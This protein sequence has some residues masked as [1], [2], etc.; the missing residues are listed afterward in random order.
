MKALALV[1]AAA[2]LAGCTSNPLG[3][4]PLTAKEAQGRAD[5]AARQWQP[6]AV[7]IGLAAPE[8]G[9]GSDFLGNGNRSGNGGWPVAAEP[10][11]S[12]GDGRLPQ[13]FLN[14]RSA[15]T[16]R[17]LAVL[18][19]QN[20]TVRTEPDAGNGEDGPPVASWQVDSPQAAQVAMQDANFSAAARASDGGIVYV[21]GQGAGGPQMGG[22]DPFWVLTAGSEQAD[23]GGIVFVNARTGER[24]QVPFFG[25][26]LGNLF[27]GMF[28]DGGSFFTDCPP[29]HT[30]FSG[31]VTLQDS[32][33]EHPV[34]F[35]EGC[36]SL[37]LVLEWD[38][39]LP[40]DRVALE[41]RDD[42]GRA[43]EADDAEAT[44]SSV[45]ASYRGLRP[46]TYTAVLTLRSEGGPPGV[47][48]S[49]DYTLEASVG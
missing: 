10:D 43:V 39:T 38:S 47:V 21:L 2:V 1:L 34:E 11:G 23:T 3:G 49:A 9:P 4:G 27:G 20:G 25:G 35:P 40:T 33:A 28:G 16:N 48:A 46:G 32:E 19:Y 42:A 18:V 15:S 17:S 5:P 29:E 26:D 45:A 31:S 36:A 12:V 6:D 30:T 13:W 24:L 14:Y 44:Q 22:N 37:E 8:A 41:L 7:L